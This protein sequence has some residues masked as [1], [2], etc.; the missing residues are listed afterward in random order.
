MS[1]AVCS[2]SDTRVFSVFIVLFVCLALLLLPQVSYAD[3]TD[4]PAGE[5]TK[6]AAEPAQSAGAPAKSASESSSST[7]RQ[8]EAGSIDYGYMADDR[9]QEKSE[10]SSDDAFV[11]VDVVDDFVA[12]MVSEGSNG[13]DSQETQ[14]RAQSTRWKRSRESASY[15]VFPYV[16][17]PSTEQF[18]ASIAEQAREIGQKEGLYASVMIAQAILESG[19]GSSGL[20]KPPYN[21]LFGIKGSY[22]G[23]SVVLMTS[24]DDGTGGKYD[25]AAGF[26]RYPSV[27][28]SLEDYADLLKRSMGAF[29]APA[30]KANAKT[31]VQ[32][33]NYLQGHYATDTSYSGKLQGLIIAY[34]LTRY[35]HPAG[36][37]SREASQEERAAAAR[38]AFENAG[39]VARA[40]SAQ[41]AVQLSDGAHSEA[42]AESGS[43]KAENQQPLNDPGV[44]VSLVSLGALVLLISKNEIALLVAAIKANIGFFL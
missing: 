6:S 14:S 39:S 8:L 18:I 10:A 44:Q 22:K 5:S 3:E 38:V 35:D 27:K 4:S 29:Y 16:P 40:S 1:R 23:A 12:V 31:Y 11:D 43:V 17:N 34:D 32:A 24:E 7:D 2:N 26:R 21:N 25:I 15:T 9:Q 37:S 19:S 30:W 36:W 42:P 41:T 33:C 20:S 13:V 28:E